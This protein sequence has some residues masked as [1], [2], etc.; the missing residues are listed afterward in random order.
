[1][2]V[3]TVCTYVRT[4]IH[5]YI[6]YVLI[7]IST[8]SVEHMS[9]FLR[10]GPPLPS[11]LRIS[12]VFSQTL[13]PSILHPFPP[14]ITPTLLPLAPAHLSLTLTPCAICQCMYLETLCMAAPSV[15][16]QD[17]ENEVK[18][19]LQWVLLTSLSLFG[20]VV[21]DGVVCAILLLFGHLQLLPALVHCLSSYLR[22]SLFTAFLLLVH[23]SS[24]LPLSSTLSFLLS[25]T[26]FSSLLSSSARLL[27][28]IAGMDH[29]ALVDVGYK[30]EL[31]IDCIREWVGVSEVGVVLVDVHTAE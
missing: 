13:P 1:M 15:L 27:L 7:C 16:Y 4:Y 29:K 20:I 8:D 3:H 31:P 12:T 10:T 21:S 6:L 18:P 11:Q 28:G 14:A 25:I 26:L 30:W 23:S 19:K 9:R 17:L 2:Y 5:M 22:S 24:T